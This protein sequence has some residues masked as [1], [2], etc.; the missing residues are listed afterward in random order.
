MIQ[1]RWLW[2]LRPNRAWSCSRTKRGRLEPAVG[3]KEAELNWV[4]E[5]SSF[6]RFSVGNALHLLGTRICLAQFQAFC[7]EGLFSRNEIYTG[8]P[9]KVLFRMLLET[10]CTGSITSSRHP[11]VW[12]LFCGRFLPRL[13]GINR[14]QVI[15]MGTFGS[16]ALNFVSGYFFLK[17]KRLL[18]VLS[19]WSNFVCGNVF[20]PLPSRK[21]LYIKE[22]KWGGEGSSLSECVC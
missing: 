7:T 12:K 8:C 5:D 13:S 1:K 10:W 15:W 14:Y 2:W 11:C 21:I 20:L 16:T 17:S 18:K 22:R 6:Q 3:K 4:T 9:K 19:I